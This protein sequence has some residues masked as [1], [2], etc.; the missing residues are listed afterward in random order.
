MQNHH[1]S[2]EDLQMVF[3]DFNKAFDK[4]PRR[5]VGQAINVQKHYKILHLSGAR[6]V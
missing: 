2:K 1:A 4:I 3:I 5:L 6:Y